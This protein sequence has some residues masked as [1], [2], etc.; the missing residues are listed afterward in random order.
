MGGSWE[1]VVKAHLRKDWTKGS[2]RGVV[3]KRRGCC[4]QSLLERGRARKYLG[5]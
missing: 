1:L 2:S 4:Q 5:M 3:V